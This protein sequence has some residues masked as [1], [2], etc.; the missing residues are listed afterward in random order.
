MVTN[1][2]LTLFVMAGFICE[3]VNTTI[4]G[5]GRTEMTPIAF[6]V[7]SGEQRLIGFSGA[8]FEEMI[9]NGRDRIRRG[10]FEAAAFAYEGFFIVNGSKKLAM[11]IE[12]TS[13]SGQNPRT[14]VQFLKVAAD[15]SR[16]LISP[17]LVFA[18]VTQPNAKRAK[19]DL[20][21]E[22]NAQEA[23]AFAEGI[24]RRKKLESQF[25][26]SGR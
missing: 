9:S 26:A 11:F 6:V 8:T 16:S 25:G 14:I 19:A 1:S 20:P 12:L 24:R 15:G 10:E 22:L 21:I 23:R 4:L 17:P 7:E 5:R 3:H 13:E 2:I 18:E